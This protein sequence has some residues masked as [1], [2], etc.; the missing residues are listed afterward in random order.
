[1]IN[2]FWLHALTNTRALLEDHVD[3]GGDCEQGNR[4]D[5]ALD[6]G[7]FSLFWAMLCANTPL[8]NT[9]PARR[10]TL[11]ATRNLLA[12][13][14]GL[15]STTL[16]FWVTVGYYHAPAHHDR[17][18]SQQIHQFLQYNDARRVHTRV[19]RSMLNGQGK[20]RKCSE[21]MA[22]NATLH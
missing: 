2:Y 4:C 15:A 21:L 1:M 18:T 12:A 6:Q 11:H 5:A 8:A 3:G 7:L 17:A 9:N 14:R 13:K 22:N 19:L 20:R 10:I 16:P